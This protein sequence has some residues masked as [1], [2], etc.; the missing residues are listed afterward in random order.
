MLSCPIRSARKAISL[1]RS[2]KLLANLCLNEW[3]YTTAES[4]PYFVANFFVMEY[5][6]ENYIDYIGINEN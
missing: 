4:I 5:N 2:K 6:I 1:H 3:G